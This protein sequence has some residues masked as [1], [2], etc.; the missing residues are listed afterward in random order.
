MK[1]KS[2]LIGGIIGLI[3]GIMTT[4]LLNMLSYTS[5]GTTYFSRGILFKIVNPLFVFQYLGFGLTR[6]FLLAGLIAF[7]LWTLIGIL[8]GVT[9]KKFNN[10]LNNISKGKLKKTSKVFII[11]IILEIIFVILLSFFKVGWPSPCVTPNFFH[12]FGTEMAPGTG[13][14]QVITPAPTSLFY[15]MQYLLI[16]TIIIFLIYLGINK[17]NKF[18]K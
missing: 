3:I 18:I 4:I 2:I 11:L 12:P 15:L 9:V 7:V 5:G 16:L 14:I 6:S 13:C 1:N 17:L 8:I 10:S